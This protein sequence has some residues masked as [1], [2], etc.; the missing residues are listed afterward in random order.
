MSNRNKH[1]SEIIRATYKIGD[2]LTLRNFDPD[3]QPAAYMMTIGNQYKIRYF[4]ART[5]E[6][7][8]PAAGYSQNWYYERFQSGLKLG[9]IDKVTGE[10]GVSK[11]V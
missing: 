1:A 6:I 3:Y 8:N 11:N 2:Y 4:N 10:R 5:V 7:W 9:E